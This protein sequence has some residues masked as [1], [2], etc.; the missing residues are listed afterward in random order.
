MYVKNENVALKHLLRE[1]KSRNCLQT[2]KIH[3]KHVRDF[4]EPVPLE[5]C[6][7]I[8]TPRLFLYLKQKPYS[9]YLSPVPTEMECNPF[10]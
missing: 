2:L 4:I 10:E 3:S 9:M 1:I 8:V 5:Q 7:C 6:Y